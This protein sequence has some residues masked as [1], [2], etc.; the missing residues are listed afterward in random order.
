MAD[1]N[2]TA[3]LINSVFIGIVLLSLL[4][5]FILTVNNEGQGEIFDNYPEIEEFNLNL[6][7]SYTNQILDTSNTNANLSTSYNPELAISAADQSGNAM[8]IN[9]QNLATSTWDSIFIFGRLIFGNIWTTLISGLLSAI[10]LFMLT[11][12]FIKWIR[13]GD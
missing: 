10:I 13:R 9:M 8:G 4:S 12:Y 6:T 1:K 7:R 5:F 2:I 3:L 11:S